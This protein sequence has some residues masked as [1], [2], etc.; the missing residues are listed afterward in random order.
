LDDK[1]PKPEYIKKIEEEANK[2][3]NETAKVDDKNANASKE[4]SAL[5]ETDK[6]N[7]TDKLNSTDKPKLTQKH[8]EKLNSKI[9]DEEVELIQ[10]R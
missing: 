9:E 3:L 2:P 1:A 4:G 5:N 7:N 6:L 8:D 10:L